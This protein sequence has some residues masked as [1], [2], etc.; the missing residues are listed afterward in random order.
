MADE[1]KPKV[2]KVGVVEYEHVGREYLEE[3]A[4]RKTAGAWLIWALGVAYVISGEYYGWQFGFEQGVGGMLLA[5][6]LIAAMYTFMVY[7]IAEMA[8]AMPVTGGPYAFGRRALGIW[9]G[10]INGLGATIEY[11]LAVSVI[12]TGIGLYIVGLAAT[13][14]VDLPKIIGLDPGEWVAL[15]F[16]IVFLAIHLLGVRETLV[17]VFVIAAIAS[18]VLVVWFLYL[19]PDI[20]WSRFTDVAVEEGKLGAST[21]F[22]T[23]YIGILA[24]VPYAAW[25]YLAI[26]GCPLAAE[27]T[28][29][30]ARDVPR[31][32]IAAM[33]TLVAFSALAFLA[34]GGTQGASSLSTTG[35]PIGDPVNAIHGANAFYWFVVIIGLTGLV[36][37]FHSIIFA[38][39][40]IVYALSRAGY[41]PRFLSLTTRNRKVPASAILFPAVVSFAM[42]V[43]L[44][45]VLVPEGGTTTDGLIAAGADLIQISVFSALITYVVMNLSFIVLRAQEPNLERPYR[46][47]GGILMPAISLAIAVVSLFAGVVYTSVT[48]WTILWTVVGFLVGL[49]YFWLY[50]RHRLV[51]EA[52]E[53]EFAVIAK[54]EA[55]I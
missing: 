7:G 17:S 23:G 18:V 49:A 24:A 20:T 47:P 6:I 16:F 46:T 28:R 22:P 3:R 35:N 31:G 26:E 39:A 54:A 13:Q 9:G 43:I 25:F 51:A 53:E 48:R 1:Q 45:R 29:N 34:A 10:Y 30:P 55:E 11:V 2:E 52:P 33:F 42:I 40:R 50:S 37:S 4:L 36:A 19:L 8:A 27:E 32:S 12:G 21:W 38:Y 41:F 14:E 15:A 44:A 5:T